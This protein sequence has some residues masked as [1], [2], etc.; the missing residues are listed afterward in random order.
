MW[1]KVFTIWFT[2]TTLL[3]PGLCCCSI[4]HFVP[5]IQH[6]SPAA[7]ETTPET[8]CSCCSHVTTLE[9]VNDPPAAPHP[10][11]APCPCKEKKA[12]LDSALPHKEAGTD[13][14][15]LS[16]SWSGWLDCFYGQAEIALVPRGTCD[17]RTPTILRTA[18]ARLQVLQVLRC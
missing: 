18:T 4:A 7:S 2:I 3:G 9:K 1:A 13:L 15:R 12:Q 8:S 17:S 5:A 16:A 6:D 10:H 14:L 11:K